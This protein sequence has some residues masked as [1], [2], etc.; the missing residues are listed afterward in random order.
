MLHNNCCLIKMPPKYKVSKEEIIEA[1]LNLVRTDGIEAMTARAV[2]NRLGISSRPI[3]TWFDGMQSLKDAVYERAR[4]LYRDYLKR[5]LQEKIPFLGVGLNILNFARNEKELYKLLF[6]SGP[7][8]S[9][10]GVTAALAFS[11]D[12]CRPSIMKIYR[13]EEKSAD[14]YFRDMFLVAFAFCTMIVVDACPYTDSEITAILREFSISI[15]K[16]YKE[17]PGLVTGNFNVD[18]VFHSILKIKD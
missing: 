10:G 7:K 3:F 5:G 4:L 6:L 12:I 15:C 8:D 9:N 2:G 11:Q 1:A 17:I 13:M 16:A 14:N 18:E